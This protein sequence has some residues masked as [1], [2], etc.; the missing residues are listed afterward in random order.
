MSVIATK[1]YENR[2]EI[3]SDSLVTIYNEFQDKR[4]KLFKLSNGII[5]GG[6]GYMKDLFLF[7][8]Y[9]SKLNEREFLNP[10]EEDVLEIYGEFI[11]F[12][13]SKS[14]NSYEDKSEYLLV[15]GKKV[16]HIIGYYIKQVTDFDAI[17]SGMFYAM[18]TLHLGYSVEK[19]CQVACDFNPYCG[20]PIVKYVIDL[21]E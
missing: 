12:A 15:L 18:A 16:F 4:V 5:M 9:L 19:A 13:K 2:I 21:K 7:Q 20:E 1:I 14:D 6:S 11:E 8:L 10:K 3:A 17:G